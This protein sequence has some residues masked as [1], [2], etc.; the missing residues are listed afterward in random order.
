M[1]VFVGS[2]HMGLEEAIPELESKHPDLEFV[3][4][5]KREDTLEMIADADI[6]LG[7]LSQAAFASRERSTI[8]STASWNSDAMT[9]VS[10]R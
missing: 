1:K 7:W 6:Y 4:C 5:P 9:W 2:N 8:S 3:H 10:S